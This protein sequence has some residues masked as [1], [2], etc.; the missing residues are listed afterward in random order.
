MNDSIHDT[1]FNLQP[2]ITVGQAE[3]IE[4]ALEYRQQIEEECRRLMQAMLDD[5]AISKTWRW[6][7]R[8]L[9]AKWKVRNS[10]FEAAVFERKPGAVPT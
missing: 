6:E 5:G 8:E 7:V 10:A 3:R 2:D 1:S 4:K 9:L